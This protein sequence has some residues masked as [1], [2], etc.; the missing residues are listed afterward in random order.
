MGKLFLFLIIIFVFISCTATESFHRQPQP[1]VAPLKKINYIIKSGDSLWKISK[2]YG[3]TPEELMKINKIPSPNNLQ[4]GQKILIPHSEKKV[5]GDFSW[6]LKGNVVN[7]F[8]ENVDNSVN[9]GLNIQTNSISKEVKSAAKG[10]VVFA[11]QLK[12]WG[13]TVILQHL[14]DFYT[15]YANLEPSLIKE[16]SIAKSNQIIGN[17]ASGKS[18]NHILHF[19]I[20]KRYIPQDPLQYLN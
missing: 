7:F 1:E 20:R 11:N 5:K 12:G 14:G 10:K 18:G 8:G 17:V 4:I 9:R 6:P 15:I 2:R 16:G 19:E 13:H 3:T